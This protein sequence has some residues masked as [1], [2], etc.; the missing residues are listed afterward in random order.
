MNLED[1]LKDSNYKLSQFTSEEIEQ[2][3]QSITTKETK[4][5]IVPY[6]VCLVR[7]KAIKLTPEEVIRQLYLRVLSDRFHYPLSRIQVEYGVNFGREVKRA[8]IVIMDK[9]RPNTVYM[10]VEVKKPKLK[11]G[12]NQL[13]SYCNATGAPIAIWTNGEQISYQQRKDP[14]YFED[15]P[16]LPNANQT[17]ADILQIKFTFQD[18]IDNDKL[19]KENKSLKTLIEEMEDEV[20]ANAGVDVFEK[21]FKLIFTKLY[22]EWYSGQGNR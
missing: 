14:N 4:K 18:L 22:D 9:D 21:L 17:L 11:D 12:K 10:V 5:G 7:Q 13:R 3:E 15:I 8:D 19:E 16:G 1:I 20:L 2:L 6:T